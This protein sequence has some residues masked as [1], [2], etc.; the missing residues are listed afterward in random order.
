MESGQEAP[1]VMITRIERFMLVINGMFSSS[2]FECILNELIDLG[3]SKKIDLNYT[4]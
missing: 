2:L 4:I 1:E 3:Y